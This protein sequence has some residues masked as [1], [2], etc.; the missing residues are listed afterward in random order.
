[1]YSVN[2]WNSTGDPQ[3]KHKKRTCEKGENFIYLFI[4]LFIWR[5]IEYTFPRTNI[6]DFLV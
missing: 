1:M 4:Y 3:V 5:K 2:R 6:D